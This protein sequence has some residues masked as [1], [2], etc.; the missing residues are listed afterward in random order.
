MD[1][2]LSFQ[3]CLL[4]LLTENEYTLTDLFQFPEEICKE[5]PNFYMSGLHVDTFFTNILLD[6]TFDI[7]RVC[8]T[9]MRISKRS[10]R[11]LFC[12]LL[13][14]VTKESFFIKLYIH[15]SLFTK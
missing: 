3:F 8:I 1:Y 7:C 12:I 14:V 10:F 5:D 15:L 6:K 4:T 2:H 13:N 9:I 11:I